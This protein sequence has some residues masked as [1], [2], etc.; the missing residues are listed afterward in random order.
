MKRCLYKHFD[1]NTSFNTR[2]KSYFVSKMCLARS[3]ML[4]I[5]YGPFTVYWF[6]RILNVAL[7]IE[8]ASN[9]AFVYIYLS[10]KYRNRSIARYYECTDPRLIS[11]RRKRLKRSDSSTI[12]HSTFGK[13]SHEAMTLFEYQSR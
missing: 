5:L 13:M 7:V 3:S 2:F 6:N 12:L 8:Y 1:S 9:I 10:M 4:S 11:S